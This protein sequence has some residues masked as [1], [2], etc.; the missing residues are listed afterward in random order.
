MDQKCNDG[1]ILTARCHVYVR[2]NGLSQQVNG[3]PWV[4]H[5]RGG[6]TQ[7][8]V[9]APVDGPVSEAVSTALNC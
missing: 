7:L 5:I 4:C 8:G 2:D 3:P 9:K 1:E 6:A